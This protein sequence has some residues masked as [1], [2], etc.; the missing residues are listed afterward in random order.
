MV[1][2]TG[3]RLSYGVDNV[4]ETQRRCDALQPWQLNAAVTDHAAVGDVRSI[5]HMTGSAASCIL[6]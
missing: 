6:L 2:S 1:A 4:H 5:S 3:P